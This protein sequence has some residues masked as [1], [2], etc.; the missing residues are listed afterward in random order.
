VRTKRYGMGDEE[1]IFSR[2]RR[3][4]WEEKGKLGRTRQRNE[5]HKRRQSATEAC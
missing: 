5:K 2:A 4:R 3:K 1:L